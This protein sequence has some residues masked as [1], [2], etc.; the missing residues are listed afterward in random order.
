MSSS[1]EPRT[2]ELVVTGGFLTA[3]LRSQADPIKSAKECRLG[4]PDEVV[5]EIVAGEKRIAGDS[6]GGFY[7]EDVPA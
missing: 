7:V 6:V 2:R 5:K 1:E 4:I 3:L